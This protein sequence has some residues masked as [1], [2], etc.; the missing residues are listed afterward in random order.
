MK[1]STAATT[2]F[3]AAKVEVFDQIELWVDGNQKITAWN[4]SFEE[5]EPNAFSIVQ[6]DDCPYRTPTCEASCYVHG[7]EKHARP[8]HDLYRHNSRAIRELLATGSYSVFDDAAHAF[9]DWI[10]DHCPGGFRWHVSGDVFSE[11]YAEW[12][13]AVCRESS[14][15]L[16]WIYTRSFPLVAPLLEVA[17][18][19][20]GNLAINCSA[21]RD[22]Y[23]LARRFADEHGLRVCYMT[24]DGATPDDMREG[25]VIFPDYALR[26]ATGSPAEKR[27]GS[28]F[29]L[30]LAPEQRRM[31]CPV[32][33]YGKSD[34]CRCGP[35]DRCLK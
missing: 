25:D 13:A 26:P 18:V 29:Y 7:L 4:G 11:I 1:Q 12:I 35:C 34:N 14:K 17:T 3:C 2:K 9:G 27:D 5:P 31:V 6:V 28:P 8:T 23:W 21:D 30:Q 20:G 33:F 16:H 19:A 24:S 10:A 22:N 32:D 15:T